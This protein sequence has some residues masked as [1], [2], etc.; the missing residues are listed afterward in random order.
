MDEMAHSLVPAVV[1]LSVVS[2]LIF[3]FG[4]TKALL[5]YFQQDE[6]DNKRFL[7]W[8]IHA[9]AFDKR[10]TLLV[11][12]GLMVRSG[13]SSDGGVIIA[14]ILMIGGFLGGALISLRHLRDA[15]KPL[16]MTTRA[17]RILIST[18]ILFLV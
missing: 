5:Q 17:K 10:T 16:V 18:N 7:R 2:L 4:R 14:H 9:R 15:K 12:A 3:M 13:F 8:I 1:G 6:Y 11:L